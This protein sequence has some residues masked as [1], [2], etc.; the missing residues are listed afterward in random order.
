M[1]A[2]LRGKHAHRGPARPPPNPRV[3]CNATTQR[4]NGRQHACPARQEGLS[5]HLWPDASARALVDRRSIPAENS[6]P[7]P[8]FSVGMHPRADAS[9]IGQKIT[10]SERTGLPEFAPL[11]TDSTRRQPWAARSTGWSDQHRL[12]QRARRAWSTAL[13]VHRFELI[14]ADFL[15]QRIAIDPEAGRRTGLNLAA[16]T[17]HL[18]DQ[19]PFDQRHH[20]V[21]QIRVLFPRLH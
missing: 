9:G 3:S 18:R 7:F 8:L 13:L 20:A 14:I 11:Y 5:F 1:L 15:M 19:F 2:P 12:R 4:V 6:A 16:G 10:A 17:E 21:V